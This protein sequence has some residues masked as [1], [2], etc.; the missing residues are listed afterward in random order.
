MAHYVILAAGLIIALSSI[1]LDFT[2]FALFASALG[3]GL[4]FG[5]QNLVSNFVAGLIVLFERSLNVGDFVELES[6]VAGE[7]REINMRST[8]ITTN[9]NVDILVPN[10]EFVGGRVTNWT[11]REVFRRIHIP[12]GV[13]YGTNKE[14]VREVV[15]E[16]SE[17]VPWTL[18]GQPR[19]Q[20]QVW[21]VGF[22]DS[23]LDFELVVWLTPEAVKRPTAVQADFLWEIETGLSESG[24]EIPF[25][26][27]DLHLRSGFDQLPGARPD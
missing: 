1:G 8:L 9:D 21:F 17:R 15:L 10:S 18:R 19:R 11:L 20:P 5:L 22:G 4:G 14:R 6:G 23:S 24:I 7:V 25:P 2:K 16:A 3:V 13:A 27:R 12:F 26:Q